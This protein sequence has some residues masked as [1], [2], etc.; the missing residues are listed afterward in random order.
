MNIY[1]NFV[2]ELSDSILFPLVKGAGYSSTIFT[3]LTSPYPTLL[4]APTYP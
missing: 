3:A 1:N 4:C 2:E